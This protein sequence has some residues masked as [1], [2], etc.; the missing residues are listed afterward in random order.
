MPARKEKSATEV[1]RVGKFG[2]VGIINTLIDFTIY[3]LLWGKAHWAIV[4]ANIVSTTV[5]MTFSFFANKNLVFKKSKGSILR[6][7]IIFYA[8][9]AF[10]LY[11]LQ[12]G[13]MNIL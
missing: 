13:T 12:T 9:T 2:V 10:G 6:Q 7:A 8:V 3:D 4:P 11:V 5:A 1:K